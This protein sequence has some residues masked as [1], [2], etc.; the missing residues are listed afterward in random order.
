MDIKMRYLKRVYFVVYLSNF[1]SGSP[2][3]VELTA[4]CHS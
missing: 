2:Y 3:A 4:S 1:F